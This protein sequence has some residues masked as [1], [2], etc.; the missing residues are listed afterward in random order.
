MKRALAMML[1]AVALL[2]GAEKPR[3]IVLPVDT[4]LFQ[5]SDLP[6]YALVNASC[7]TCHSVDYTKYQPPTSPRSYWK[8][9]VTKMQKTFGAPIPDA[10]LDAIVDYLVKTYGAEK[11][12]ETP[13]G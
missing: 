5:P 11:L 7:L 6:G 2:D 8:A 3:E 12:A 9:T 4:E 13:K 10:Q 1:M